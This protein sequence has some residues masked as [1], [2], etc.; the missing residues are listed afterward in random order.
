[1]G[2]D[3]VV[4]GG[5]VIGLACAR[6]LAREG[7]AVTVLDR[8]RAGAESSWAGGGIL[9]PL[10]PWDYGAAVNRLARWSAGLYPDWAGELRARTGIDPE[11]RQSGM[12]VLDAPEPA[13]ALAWCA[14]QGEPAERVDARRIVPEIGRAGQG[15]W[16]PA[17]AQVRN[18]RLVK[19]LARQLEQD[20]VRIVE[21]AAVTGIATAGDR[22]TELNTAAGPFSAGAYVV[23]AGAWSGVVLDDLAPTLPIAPVRG[24]MLLFKT[25]PGRLP[26]VLLHCGTYLI[27]RS[28]GHVLVGSTLEQVGFDKGTTPE[29]AARLHAAAAEIFPPLATLRPL[30]HW[31]GLRPGSPGNVP[32]IARHPALDNLY[33]NGGH[34]RYGVTM[35]PGSAR[36]LANLLAGR[37]QP[38]DCAPY[39]W[40][41]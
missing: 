3:F 24:Q 29:A 5:G 22:V 11:Y 40:P 37:D 36:L 25:D 33:L 1:M 2:A 4:V 34:F 17:V 32:V 10:L 30:R 28:D 39:R 16:L 7:A 38:F 15:L 23:A 27:P 19:A 9:F 41:D 31:A 8:G 12:L 26:A 35:A 14:E 21:G 13:G 20:G 18:P 6:E